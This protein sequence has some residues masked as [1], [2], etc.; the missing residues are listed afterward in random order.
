MKFTIRDSLLVTAI[1]ALALGWM[2]DRSRLARI[3]RELT[4]QSNRL[5]D[6]RALMVVERERLEEELEQVRSDGTK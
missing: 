5:A 3:N 4:T 6:T 2:L 1:V